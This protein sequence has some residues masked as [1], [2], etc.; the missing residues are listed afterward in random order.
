[1]VNRAFLKSS[2]VL[3]SH[4]ELFSSGVLP[5]LWEG[6]SSAVNMSVN[7]NMMSVDIGNQ[8][9]KEKYQVPMAGNWSEVA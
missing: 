7:E 2:Y 5:A 1:V 4:L 8:A 3:P 6:R 9:N